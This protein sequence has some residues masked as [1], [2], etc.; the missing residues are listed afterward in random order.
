MSR[1]QGSV[2][3]RQS[4]DNFSFPDRNWTDNLLKTHTWSLSE[5]P[6]IEGGG[7]RNDKASVRKSYS[8][9]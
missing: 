2:G 3:D 7:R 9:E 8:V 1:R 6:E 4:F 5:T